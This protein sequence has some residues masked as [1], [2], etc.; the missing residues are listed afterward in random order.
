MVYD[1]KPIGIL[2]IS[3]MCHSDKHALSN[4]LF[5]KE[6]TVFYAMVSSVFQELIIQADIYNLRN[7]NTEW[8]QF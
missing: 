1:F 7:L 2:D 4:I 3:K 8:K 6:S 5:K